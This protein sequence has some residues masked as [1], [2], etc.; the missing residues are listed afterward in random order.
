[1]DRLFRGLPTPRIPASPGNRSHGHSG[2]PRAISARPAPLC[3]GADDLEGFSVLAGVNYPE[4]SKERAR[5]AQ[6]RLSL[7]AR[8]APR[9]SSEQAVRNHA[10]LRSSRVLRL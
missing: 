8:R 4:W 6:A 3:R 2:P 7:Q 10:S 9:Q 1:M 5:P